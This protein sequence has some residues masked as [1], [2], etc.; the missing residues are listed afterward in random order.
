[1]ME[2]DICQLYYEDLLDYAQGVLVLE[3][4]ENSRATPPMT[5]D[6]GMSKYQRGIDQQMQDV[7][8]FMFPISKERQEEEEKARTSFGERKETY[9]A[10]EEKIAKERGG[11]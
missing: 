11:H 8:D 6:A 4:I 2:A 1:M 7:W 10:L 9:R 5:D 3:G